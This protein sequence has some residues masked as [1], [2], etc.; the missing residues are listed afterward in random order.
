MK[1]EKPQNASERD[2][3]AHT[4]L[5]KARAVI[6]ANF[7][8][9]LEAPIERPRSN[10]GFNN[11]VFIVNKEYIFRFP[12]DDKAVRHLNREIKL[13]PLLAK[14][15]TLT[16]PH[17]EFMGSVD[18]NPDHPFVGYRLLPGLP[19]N[20]WEQPKQDRETRLNIAS[21]IGSALLE[22]HSV[23]PLFVP[24]PLQEKTDRAPRKIISDFLE[25]GRTF[26]FQMIRGKIGPDAEALIQKI[27][28]LLSHYVHGDENFA[29]VRTT[30][31]GDFALEHILVNPASQEISGIIDWSTLGSGDPAEDFWRLYAALDEETMRSI[32]STYAKE[33]YEHMLPRMRAFTVA[34][35][36]YRLKRNQDILEQANARADEDR[37]KAV[38]KNNLL[39][40]E[41]LRKHA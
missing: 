28:R 22:L 8:Q 32:F 41:T 11:D 21:K 38:E 29:F 24:E 4:E 39:V 9:F 30:V 13:L 23:D 36:L 20:E 17:F 12:K 37:K 18:S 26:A 7:P 5:E 10:A 1:F 6:T 25:I 15:T 35:M 14:K 19:L 40:L 33:S 2:Y 16:V 34:N 27:E 3:Y 31:H